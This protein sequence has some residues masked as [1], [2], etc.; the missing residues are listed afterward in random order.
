MKFVF[1]VVVS[2]AALA[3]AAPHAPNAPFPHSTPAGTDTNDPNS[4]PET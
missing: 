3:P 2:T 4:V 1:R